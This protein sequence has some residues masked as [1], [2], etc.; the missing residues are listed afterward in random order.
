MIPLMVHRIL[1][2]LIA[3]EWNCAINPFPHHAAAQD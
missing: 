3:V 2:G 1:C